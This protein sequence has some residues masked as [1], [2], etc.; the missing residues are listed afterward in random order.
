[1]RQIRASRT[2]LQTQLSGDA[3]TAWNHLEALK[4]ESSKWAANAKRC[5]ILDIAI[6]GNLRRSPREDHPNMVL[7][8]VTF[9]V[10]R[11]LRSRTSGHCTALVHAQN[12]SPVWANVTSFRRPARVRQSAGEP[13][14]GLG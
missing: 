12:R 11:K 7:W 1:M 13:E 6:L 8:Y 9:T 14:S 5:E 2:N 4:L 10:N 3:H